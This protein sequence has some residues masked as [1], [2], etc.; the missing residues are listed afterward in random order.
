MKVLKFGGSS[1]GTPESLREVRRIVERAPKPV[2]VV[3]SALH[4]VT[5]QL[6][7]AS[8]QAC[9]G[10]A[11]YRDT[12]AAIRQRHLQMVRDCA[13]A[14]RQNE[15]E[16]VMGRR[17][18]D[19]ES[20]LQGIF[21]TEDLTPKTADAVM[22]YGE[23][24]S[25]HLV[26]TVLP[27]AVRYDARS[28]VKT[29]RRGRENLVDFDTTNALV[30]DAFAT[31][32]DIAVVGGFISRDAAT[33]VT[34]TLGRGGSD[35]T[36]AIIAA[37]LDA[38]ALE[39]WTDVDGFMTADPRVIPSAYTIPELSYEEATELCN[40]GA[41]VV[42]P[43]TIYPVR[44]KDIPIYVKNT[45][46]PAHPG[47]VI[48]ADA[49]PAK[50]PVRGISSVNETSM[51]T[52]S[53]MSMVGVTGI[54]RRIFGRLASAGISVFM[55]A[56]TSSETSTSLCV[57]PEDGRRACE[58]LD[59]E[60]A[61][62]IAEGS[63][64]P[65]RLAE[66]LATVA[67]V[68]EYMK[69]VPG[70]MGRLFTT[71]GRNG[72]SVNASATGALELNISLVVA[73]SQLRKALSV[74]HD[75]FFLSQHQDL[76]VFLCGTGTVGGSLL[77][78]IE[79]ARESLLKERALKINV[80]GI[81]TTRCAAYNADG[82]EPCPGHYEDLLRS[83]PQAGIA[84]MVE[85]IK[86]MNLYN[87]VFVDCTA[88]EEVAARYEELLS[89]NVSI[90]TANKVAASSEFA[91]YLRLKQT[92]RERGVKFLFE[93][94]VGAGLPIINT[95]RDLTG[96]GDKILRIEAVLSGTLNFVFNA[97]SADVPFSEAVRR[98]KEQGYSEPDP[99]IDLSGKDVIRKLT[100]LARE[101]GY[102]VETA[103]IEAQPF[104]PAAL[105]EAD[106]ETFWAQLPVLDASFETERRRLEA[107]GK[108]WRYVATWADGRGT[109][110]LREI[111]A[112]HPFY[113]IE[114]SNN[115]ILLTTARYREYP[116]LIQG[117]GA[118]ADV[119]AAGVFADIMRVGNV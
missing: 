92:A 116:M 15:L 75:S 61:R 59:S 113:N 24:L 23:R 40:F 103:D 99:R 13:P 54:N 97:L 56:Q 102:R 90:V 70:I 112:D 42:Y 66:S 28:F 104:L 111:A 30:R 117:Y 77:R 109:V 64:N 11:A 108:H 41:K 72:I 67:V 82:L 8:R 74:L 51:V 20:I 105:F 19:L 118:G 9:Q 81:T 2:I 34:T 50:T 95:I 37:A 71:L 38:E 68:G 18:S 26:A 10:D 119:T 49:A 14:G 86:E 22:S 27:G 96:S 87:S 88:S 60:F 12:A 35:Y 91:R 29:V 1:V 94:N 3:V 36:A 76:N 62:E 80:A 107:E 69:Q 63:M 43:P 48:R 47:S 83:H 46:H 58:E 79:A 73:A 106:T 53:G 6:I 52:V 33:G 100:I 114:G 17:L 101:S 44:T 98:A 4:G 115:I 65:A 45:F 39:I 31:L 55:V 7:Q 57:R 89:C 85:Q 32:P 5:D 78:Q 25:S 21:L 110:G 84:G 16:A 93:T